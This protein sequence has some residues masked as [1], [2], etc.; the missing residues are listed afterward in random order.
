MLLSELERRQRA[1]G[2]SYRLEGLG[3]DSVRLVAKVAPT[4]GEV[5]TDAPP[6]RP[7]LPVRVGRGAA[8][9]T[10]GVRD[11]V[12]FTGHLAVAVA[13]V[14]VHPRSLRFRDAVGV[15]EE[16][17]IKA[18]PIIFLIGLLLGLILAFQS[19]TAMQRFGAEIFVADLL[20]LST[21]RELGPLMAA[22][23]VVARSSS[24]FAAEIG[25]M[26]VNE[27]I[28]A[29]TT[30]GLEPVR[31]LSVPREIAGVTVVPV[32]AMLM[33]LSTLAGGAIVMVSLGFPLRLYVN[34]I[35]DAV[36]PADMLGGLAKAFVFGVIVVAAGCLR[37]LQTGKGADAVG[38]STT[39]A[40]VSG[41]VL[42]AVTDGIFAV[43]FY[44]IGW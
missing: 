7:S 23:M 17:G 25:T 8:E 33:N 5:G 11:V 38:L 6:V 32:L 10:A 26:K 44:M 24:A 27:E 14:V 9:V 15:A 36:G 16:A 22:I 35:L 39:S 41:I 13:G 4:V 34:R 12:V 3:E 42:I 30:M 37:G 28:D 18:V 1:A 43:V 40:V 31:F 2:G 20:A 21:L 29:L 19:A